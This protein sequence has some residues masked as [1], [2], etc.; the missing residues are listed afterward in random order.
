MV[1]AEN[2]ARVEPELA[3]RFGSELSRLLPIL[4]VEEIRVGK[5]PNEPDRPDLVARVRFGPTTRDLLFK[6]DSLGEPRFAELAITRLRRWGRS[7][8]KSYPVFAAPYVSER[9]REICRSEEIG[10]LDLV[11]DAY[12][13]FGPVL[14]ERASDVGHPIE[15]RGVRSLLAPKATRVIRALLQAPTEPRRITE[16]AKICSMSPAGIYFVVELLETKGFVSRDQ[17]RLVLVPEPRRLLMEWAQNWSIEKSKTSRYF[18]FEKGPERLISSVS[19]KAKAM[20]I[21]YAFTG[22]AGASFVAP[23]TR[24]DDVWLYAK[25]DAERLREALDLRPVSS[26]ANVVF[27]QPYDEGVFMGAREIRGSQVVSD[28][29]LF[30]D[31]YTNPARG[32]EQAEQILE[33][34]I[35]FPGT[36]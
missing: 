32:Q 1:S 5:R 18:S 16:L 23:F 13:R 6:V 27:L 30:V 19:E 15:R 2:G 3:R 8:P 4:T 36:S 17:N 20:G 29:Q 22:M 24:Y 33:K 11:G 35:R 9:T 21:E 31:L 26:G 28:I 25:G 10:Y 7:H 12:L 34:A 14:I